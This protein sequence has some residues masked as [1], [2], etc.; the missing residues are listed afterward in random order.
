M[1]GTLVIT[2]VVSTVATVAI[3]F[4]AFVQ[5]WRE[6]RRAND[7]VDVV[8]NQISGLAFV[9]R[10]QLK[11][12]LGVSPKLDRG[13]SEW[14]DY[15]SASVASHMDSAEVRIVELMRLAPEASQSVDAGI[16][17][18]FVHFAAA[19]NVINQLMITIKPI[20]RGVLEDEADGDLRAC[21]QALESAPIKTNL[22]D[23]ARVL[24]AEKKEASLWHVG[25]GDTV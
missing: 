7:R 18:A 19:T 9:L 10:R 5:I 13:L 14:I 25:D 22:L 1:E 8:D 4:F 17:K 6:R 11:F 12:W 15:G 24:E 23:A 20:E 21:V 2:A 16:S 3:S